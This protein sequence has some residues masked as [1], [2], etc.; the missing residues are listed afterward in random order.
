MLVCPNCGAVSAN[1]DLNFCQKCGQ[2][3]F[4][5]PRTAQTVLIEPP[6]AANEIVTSKTA[7]QRIGSP[8]PPVESR[9][10]V[11]D[12]PSSG[13]INA[14]KAMAVAIVLG[15]IAIIA[16]IGWISARN[17][18]ESSLNN[19]T[20]TQSNLS[21]QR[22]KETQLTQ[23]I[24]ELETQ[25]RNEK[26]WSR[27]LA[28]SWPLTM[29][30]VKLCNHDGTEKLGEFQTRF[31]SDEIRYIQFY[32]TMQNN[33][34]NERPLTGKLGVKFILPDG[35]LSRNSSSPADYTLEVDIQELG[36]APQEF[37][38]GWGSSSSSF[39]TYGTHRIQF[40]WDGKIIGETKFEVY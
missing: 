33:F 6:P 17:E 22:D 16:A 39:F 3:S 26:D 32:A 30:E 19:L 9:Y 29:R 10:D 36:E 1:K 23:R 27:A 13:I 21:E 31:S 11:A 2:P 35:T 5:A 4:A 38:R 37:G 24:A 12:S 15:L 28:E 7:P 25:V 40:W 18:L 20:S 34:G 8:A 14:G